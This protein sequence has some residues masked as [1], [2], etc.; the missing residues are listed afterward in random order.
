MANSQMLKSLSRLKEAAQKATTAPLR[1]IDIDKVKSI[2]QVRKEFND[3]E[4]L[5]ESIRTY[6]LQM[7]INVTEADADGMYT[8]IQGERRWRA[9]KMAGL[10]TIDAII[11]P[12]PKTEKERML[13]QLTENVQRSDMTLFEIAD[14]IK[15]LMVGKAMSQ[16]DIAKALG[17]QQDYVNHYAALCKATPV[18][19]DLIVRTKVS[20]VRSAHKLV[21]FVTK[22][23][24][25]AVQA[26]E[27]AI[28]EGSKF[29]RTYVDS[30]IES[31]EHPETEEKDI[32]ITLVKETEVEEKPVTKTEPKPTKVDKPS[33]KKEDT[34]YSYI[35]EGVRRVSRSGL[36]IRV[37]FD[38]HGR[39]PQEGDELEGYLSLDYTCE[40]KDQVCVS[41]RGHLLK[42]NITEVYLTEMEDGLEDRE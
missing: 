18:M 10:K 28:V 2:E 22:H 36:R 5:A 37:A 11:R 12:S 7:P 4:E 23:G 39:V 8:I 24:Q 25:E 16:T 26:V 34:K 35:P 13:L 6:G 29:T 3:L 14:A 38:N 20:N 30:L 19:R 15:Y 31:F 17:K 33:K 21:D 41:Y 40:D 27:D 42:V 32:E 9:A 1:S